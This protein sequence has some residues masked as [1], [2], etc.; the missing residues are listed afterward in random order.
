MINQA[1]AI[2]ELL[3][4][5]CREKSCCYNSRV[6]ITGQDMWRIAQAMEVAPWDF[7]MYCEAVPRAA[8][9]FQLVYGGPLYQVVL[10]KRGEVRTT[11]APCLFLWKL[12]DGHHQCGL[13][14][15]R[16]LACQSYPSLLVDGMVCVDSRACTCRQWSVLDVDREYEKAL[17]EQ[18]LRE[19]AEYHDIVTL[20]N[21]SLAGCGERTYQAF[22]TYVL[23]T[24]TYRFGGEG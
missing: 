11:G 1:L 19:T 24:Y 7:T 4:L 20:W 9:G 21:Q 10:A 15:L 6:I 12:A 3:W 2:K 14:V 16:P 22:C 5:G 17:L 18:R 8:D 23:D 13:G